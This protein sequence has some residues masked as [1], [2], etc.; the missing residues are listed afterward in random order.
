MKMNQFTIIRPDVE[1]S[2]EVNE[3]K[4][5]FDSIPTHLRPWY[6]GVT[7]IFTPYLRECCQKVA[8]SEPVAVQVDPFDGAAMQ[9]CYANVDTIVQ[10]F[11]GAAVIG[12]KIW[13]VPGVY[14]NFEHHC[15]WR[16]PNGE[17]VCVTPQMGNEEYILFLPQQEGALDEIDAAMPTLRRD[18]FFVDANGDNN[19][20]K[21]VECKERQGKAFCENNN[22][23]AAYWDSK[24]ADYLHRIMKKRRAG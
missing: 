19:A 16:H 4:R 2:D 24:A 13:H 7:A 14:Y 22:G 3:A 1:N 17:L 15:V 23:S 12:W 10:V 18:H 8:D 21:I 11:G 5:W 9:R 6:A 20:K